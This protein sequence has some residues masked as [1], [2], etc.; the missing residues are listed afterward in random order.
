MTTLISFLGKT[1]PDPA[2]GYQRARYRFDDGQT[3]QTAF[4]GSALM[5]QLRPDRTLLLVQRFTNKLTN[6]IDGFVRQA[7][8]KPQP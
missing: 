1:R 2:T 7:R 3:V 4:F 6:E 8:R 5:Q